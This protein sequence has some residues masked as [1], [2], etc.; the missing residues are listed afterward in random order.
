M[1]LNP[2]KSLLL[3]T[4]FQMVQEL[5]FKKGVCIANISKSADLYYLLLYSNVSY[6]ANVRTGLKTID[7]KRTGGGQWDKLN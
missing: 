4:D 7:M 1:L 5:F 6:I 3:M 2:Q